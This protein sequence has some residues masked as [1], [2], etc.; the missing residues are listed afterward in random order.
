MSVSVPPGEEVDDPRNEFDT[1]ETT[2]AALAHNAV[3]HDLCSPSK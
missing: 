2:L 3:F 1:M